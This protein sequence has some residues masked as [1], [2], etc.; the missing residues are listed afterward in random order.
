MN[1]SGWQVLTAS[2]VDDGLW[3]MHGKVFALGE[4]EQVQLA[5]QGAQRA[6]GF[7][8]AKVKGRIGQSPG[9]QGVVPGRGL[10]HRGR[11]RPG[12]RSQCGRVAGRR[13]APLR[14]REARPG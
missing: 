11:R 7:G 3:T 10:R 9:L 13:P 1:D 5:Q 14:R 6:H 8:V 2:K 12:P 4:A